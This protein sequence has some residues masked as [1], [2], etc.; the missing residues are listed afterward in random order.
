[1]K[2]ESDWLE[3]S[4]QQFA[5][6]G[7]VADVSAAAPGRRA[8]SPRSRTV[9]EAAARANGPGRRWDEGFPVLR[10]LAINTT[11][12]GFSRRAIS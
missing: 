1:M 6:L 3:H 4:E 2:R 12:W 11:A 10:Q 7:G 9:P 8:I 5:A